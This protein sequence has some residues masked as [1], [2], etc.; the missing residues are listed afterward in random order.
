MLPGVGVRVVAVGDEDHL[1]VHAFLQDQ[2]DAA[3]GG[4]DAG[5]VAVVHD[6]DVLG[7]PLD[8]ADLLHGEGGAAGGHDV[9]DAQLVHGQDV[10]VAFHE[11]ALVRAGDGGLGEIDAVQGAGFHVDLRLLGIH[12]LGDGLVGEQGASAEGDD[13]AAHRMDREHHPVVEAVVQGAVRVPLGAEARFQ[14]VFVLVAL[15]LRRFRERVL[16]FR[17]PSQAVLGDGLVLEAAGME[18]LDGDGAAFVR[19]ELV[20]VEVEGELRDGEEALVPLA[21]GDVLGRFLLL[22]HLDMVLAGEIL[23]GLRVGELLVLHDEAHGRAGLA[24][25]EALVDAAG[26]LHVEGRRFLIVERAAGPQ[27]APAALQRH[28]I[29]HHV[30]DAG[31]V[32]NELYRLLRDHVLFFLE[33][34]FLGAGQV[35]HLDLAVIHDGSVIRAPR[36]GGAFHI[37]TGFFCLPQRLDA[38][39]EVPAVPEEHQATDDGAEKT[40]FHDEENAQQEEQQV[41]AQDE[42][43]MLFLRHVFSLSYNLQIYE[44]FPTFVFQIQF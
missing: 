5:R 30:F 28:E 9:R 36:L 34:H 29:A 42:E 19:R 27:A 6:G 38:E 18:I 12:V 35:R 10:Q 8:E 24:A 1:H 20:L 13:A 11:V 31:R 14:Q 7:E 26:R 44:I 2:V 39:R 17:G 4:V 33:I 25:A 43:Y 3:E 16:G 23:E 15:L 41:L 37:A 40:P 21:R 32:Q 22:L